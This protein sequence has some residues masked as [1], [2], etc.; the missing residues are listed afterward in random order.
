MLIRCFLFPFDLDEGLD[1]GDGVDAG[2]V[3]EV[4][5][6]DEEDELLD[7]DFVFLA[8]DGNALAVEVFGDAAGGAA[9]GEDV[10]EE[11]EVEGVTLGDAGGDVAEAVIDMVGAVFLHDLHVVKVAL[12]EGQLAFLADGDDVAHQLGLRQ[13]R[14]GEEES[15]R[16][17]GGDVGAMGGS[18]DVG[19]ELIEGLLVL[20]EGDDVDKV[21]ARLGEVGVMVD[22]VVVIHGVNV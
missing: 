4:G 20:E 15:A 10:V 3:V 21:D 7:F 9:G 2:V 14:G 16:L 5:E 13:Q 11:G 19:N 12:G 6:L 1:G 22:D 17:D 8:V 18:V